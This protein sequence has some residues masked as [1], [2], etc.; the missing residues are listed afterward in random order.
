MD[1]STP[2]TERPQEAKEAV[3]V[4]LDGRTMSSLRSEA[5]RRSAE[6]GR[7][8][9]PQ[10]VAAMILGEWSRARAAEKA[11]ERTARR[12]AGGGDHDADHDHGE[13]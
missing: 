11:R 13:G 8:I 10:H 9:F 4:R 12:D 3:R 5:I 7:P 1:R 2:T 6:A